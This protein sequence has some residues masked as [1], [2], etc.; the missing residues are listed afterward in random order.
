MVRAWQAAKRQRR[1]R[2][3]REVREQR[4]ADEKRRRESRLAPADPV[5]AGPRGHAKTAL[6]LGPICDRPGCYRAPVTASRA[7]ARFC[8]PACRLDV[9]RVL[10][11][12]AK[13]RSRATPVGRLKRRIEYD[14]RRRSDAMGSG[15]P[16]SYAPPT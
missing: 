10:D 15:A 5:E 2:E 14:R 9:R 3:R 8:S 11:R 13:W 16:A 1:R 12:E 6:P 4:R 7:P